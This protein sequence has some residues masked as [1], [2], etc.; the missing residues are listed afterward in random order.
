MVIDQKIRNLPNWEEEAYGDLKIFDS[1]LL[2]S[3]VFEKNDALVTQ[4]ENLIGPITLNFDLQN[5]QNSQERKGIKMTK[6]KWTF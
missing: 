3:G 5:F 1:A 4:P 2:V 6:Y